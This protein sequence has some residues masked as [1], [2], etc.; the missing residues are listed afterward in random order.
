[1]HP[2]II[3]AVILYT[4][5]VILH[6]WYFYFWYFNNIIDV[7]TYVPLISK[8]FNAEILLIAEYF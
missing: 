7:N 8:V 1:M 4:S 5:W 3:Q 2:I 6:T